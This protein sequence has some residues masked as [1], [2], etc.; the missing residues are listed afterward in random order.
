MLKIGVTFC[1]SW[2]WGFGVGWRSAQ[3]L[4]SLVHLDFAIFKVCQISLRAMLKCYNLGDP[5][6][7]TLKSKY[8]NTFKEPRF[9]NA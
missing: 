4:K 7:R 3:W 6:I 9:K 8:V 1:S 2:F 5:R